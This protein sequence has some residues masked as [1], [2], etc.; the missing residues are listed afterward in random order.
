MAQATIS[1]LV[2]ATIAFALAGCSAQ[3]AEDNADPV[4]ANDRVTSILNAGVTAELGEAEQS[5]KFLFDPLYD[6]HF[7]TFEIPSDELIEAIV[8]GAPPYHDVDAVLVSHAHGDHFSASQLTQLLSAQDSVKLVAPAQAVERMRQLDE[9]QTAF[10]ERVIAIAIANGEAAPSFEV[11][12]AT[13]EAIRTPHSGWP[14]RHVDTHNLTYRVS[15]PNGARV[16]H[17]GDA[18]PGEQHFAPHAEF[19][20][21]A[22]TGLAIVPFWHFSTEDPARLIDQTFNADGAVGMHVPVDEPG[23]LADSGWEYFNG[24]GQQVGVPGAADEPQE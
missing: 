9:W 19:F 6:N 8:T 14:E 2:A 21:D 10:E 12:G 4:D 23:W 13:I 24:L 11:S 17:F 15:A 20:A 3:G 22:R 16:M 18:D 7:G 5:V 1:A